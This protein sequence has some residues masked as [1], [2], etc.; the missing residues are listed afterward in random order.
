MSDRRRI[1]VLAKP[2]LAT[3]VREIASE[4]D[5]L[6]VVG[7]VEDEQALVAEVLRTEPDV[8]IVGLDGTDPADL[9]LELLERRP[10]L[11]ILA[12]TGQG[13]EAILW[14]LR[15]HRT[16]LGEI[17]PE[18]LLAAVSAEDWRTAGVR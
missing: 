9:Y 17:S 12:L 6:E 10:R 3:L 2:L 5:G 16:S 1:L 8:L 15:P 13:R 11:R 7:I 18:T 14:E 4:A